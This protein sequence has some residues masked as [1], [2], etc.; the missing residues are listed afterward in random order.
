MIVAVATLPGE[1]TLVG[2]RGGPWTSVATWKV[3]SGALAILLPLTCVILWRLALAI[4]SLLRAAGSSEQQPAEAKGLALGEPV[5]WQ[6][7]QRWRGFTSGRLV[8][9]SL[10][11]LGPVFFLLWM[12]SLWSSVEALTL[13]LFWTAG[14]LISFGGSILLVLLYGPA[15]L[16][17]CYRDL[18]GTMIVTDRRLA[19][20]TPFSREVYREVSSAEIV[21]AFVVEG[22][23]Q[24]GWIGIVRLKR[25]KIEDL[26]IRG[27][28]D[29]A[30]ALSVLA[31]LVR[32]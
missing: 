10:A 23:D 7:Q 24:R 26:D 29:P 12:W 15:V 6:G 28:P 16:Q 5:V 32:R 8:L 31:R 9:M 4:I 21:D 27:V 13:K 18:F 19:W 2:R 17:R 22:N 30:L 25:G 3:Q 14:A 11:A 20:L 1:T